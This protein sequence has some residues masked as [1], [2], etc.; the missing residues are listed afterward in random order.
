LDL[1]ATKLIIVTDTHLVEAGGVLHGL[2]PRAR[3]DA[4]LHNINVYHGDAVMCVFAG[5]LTDAGSEKSYENFRDAVSVLDIPWRLLIGNHDH[6]ERFCAAF[7]ETPV[8]ANGHVQS[9]VE[10][11]AGAFILMDTVDPGTHSGAYCEQRAAWLDDMLAQCTDRDVYLVM[12]HPPFEIGIPSLD[13]IRILDATP[14]RDVIKAHDN[15]RHM[16]MGHVHR[17]VS[18][19]WLGIPYTMFPATNHQ[20]VLDLENEEPIYFSHNHPGYGVL[21][22]DDERVVVHTQDPMEETASDNRR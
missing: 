12:H 5:D 22:I 20:V 3:L 18:G 14:L 7:P 8:D 15:V 2:N 11:P 6:R 17:P 1:T 10:T 19:S 9:V 16:F 4:C 21:L 13:R